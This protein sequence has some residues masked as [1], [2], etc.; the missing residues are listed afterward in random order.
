MITEM[1]NELENE[2][3][4][5]DLTFI[6]R[7]LL[8][9]KIHIDLGELSLPEKE[10]VNLKDLEIP[11]VNLK[12]L[13]VNLKDLEVKEEIPVVAIP[14][15]IPVVAIAIVVATEVNE[16]IKCGCGGKYK[17]GHKS[18]HFKTKMHLL[19]VANRI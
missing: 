10:E 8:S 18:H 4:N 11:E 14:A 13:E 7:E 17:K 12:D 3:V 15:G 2:L 6:F 5:V 9:R 1:M 16:S 19:Y